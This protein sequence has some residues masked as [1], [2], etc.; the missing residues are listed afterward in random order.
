MPQLSILIATLDG[1]IVE[2]EKMLLPQNNNWQ[3]VVAWQQ[4][5]D[6]VYSPEVK[7]VVHR[8]HN[9][10]D[11]ILSSSQSV[12]LS[13]N[14]NH[15]LQL[16]HTPYAIIADDDMRYTEEQLRCVITSFEEKEEI[17]VLCFQVVYQAGGGLKNYPPFSFLYEKRPK[18]YY[19]S[20][21]EIALRKGKVFPFFDERFG[22]GASFLCA[23]EEEVFLH[24][25]YKKGLR[26]AYLPLVV[27][28]T[29]SEGTT[30][31]RAK[32]SQRM[33]YTKGAVLYKI[34]GAIG[35]GLRCI[36]Q[37]FLPLRSS[38]FR[39]LAD[40]IKGYCYIAFN[41]K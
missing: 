36:K 1:R 5:P 18:G 7:A 35:G 22:L 41:R 17:D 20:S 27:G 4:S 29:T 26:I 6:F 25:C 32:Y 12:G 9:R 14:R 21:P 23:G 8:L 10:S 24:D 13:T 15:C 2:A 39:Q 11:V 28:T 31:T 34:Y 40:L 38:S 30:A 37:A 3:Y 16:W 33:S 19:P